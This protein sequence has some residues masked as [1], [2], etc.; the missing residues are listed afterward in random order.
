MSI[1]VTKKKKR[2]ASD[3]ELVNT[4]VCLRYHKCTS[5]TENYIYFYPYS[6]QAF[7]RSSRTGGEV[8]GGEI[9]PFLNSENITA[10][11]TKTTEQIVRPRTFPLRT[12]T[13]A[14]DVTRRKNYVMF[15]NGGH[16]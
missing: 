12:T 2:F 8:G 5:L 11:T 16:L 6:D 9:R 3:N 10:I 14:D 7:F 4:I 13:G 1:Q 15:S